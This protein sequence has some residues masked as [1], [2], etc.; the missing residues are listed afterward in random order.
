MRND[1]TTRSQ[2]EALLRARRYRDALELLA[3][4]L[5][6]PRPDWNA[7]YLAGQCHRAI[8]DP[9]TAADLLTRASRQAQDNPAVFLALGIAL[10][11]AHRFAESGTALGRAIVLDGDYALAYNS[12]AMTQKLAGDVERAAATYDAA[13][14]ALTRRLVKGFRNERTS[15]VMPGLAISGTLW[16][17]H[18]RYGAV[19]LAAGDSHV[20]GVAWQEGPT[21]TD[22]DRIRYGGLYWDVAIDEEG[23][24]SRVFLR[25]YFRAFAHTLRR[26]GTYAVLLGNRA[27]VLTLLGREQDAQAHLAEAAEFSV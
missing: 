19:Y 13:C 2:A 10:Q 3:P 24:R 8:G 14:K 5:S 12:L 26:D 15:P 21:D 11:M 20:S 1:A 16:L 7:L 22:D 23:R 17:D 6:V 9:Q 18:A 4:L 25:N 27:T